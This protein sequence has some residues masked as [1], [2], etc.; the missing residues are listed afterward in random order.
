MAVNNQKKTKKKA[1]VSEGGI[2]ALYCRLSRDDGSEGESNSIANQKKLLAR[3]AKDHGLGNTK[4]YV[5]DGYTGTN[6]NRPGFQ[7]MLE[8]MDMG[9][10]STVIVKDS[11]RFGRNYLE[12]GKYTDYYFPEHNIRFIAVND[13]EDRLCENGEDELGAFRNVMNEMYAKDISRK[14]RSSQRLRGMAGEPLSPPP[15]GYV[16]SP[17]NKKKWVIDPEAA[18]IVRKIFRL[19]LEGKGNEVIARQLQDE[20]VLVPQAY[21]QSKGLGRGGKKTQPNPYRWCKTT[22]GKILTQQ[23]YCGDVINFKTYSKSFRNKTRVENPQENWAVFRDVHEP[24]IDRETFEEVQKIVNKVRQRRLKDPEEEKSLFTNLLYCA[25]CGSRLWYH[26]ST[27]QTPVRHFFCSNYKGIR[28]TCED[29]HYIRED[30]L[31]E[32]VLSELR[33]L[34]AYLESDEDAFAELLERKSNADMIAEQKA[35]EAALATA[36]ARNAEVL[37]M[38]EK[39]YE[40]NVNGKVTDEWFMQLSHRY[41]DEKAALKKQIFE[42]NEKLN[43][44]AEANNSKESFIR[45]IRSFLKVQRLTPTLLRELIDRIDAH[46]VKGKG[47]SRTQEIVI[48]YRFIGVIDV[49]YVQHRRVVFETRQGVA[50][51]YVPKGTSTTA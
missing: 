47:K 17:E 12:V 21:W 9:Y 37:R 15:Y 32:I 24:I 28:G 3:Y 45:A 43:R 49:P 48:H 36:N 39:V 26:K 27:N 5:D 33:R 51:E 16:K 46:A 22:I 35:V 23:E 7:Q 44:L 50:I 30:A 20:K 4:F 8:D 14:V 31:T 40:D 2:T 18:E 11:S 6:F 38:Y 29:H 19:C 13:C 25:D 41:E 42:L 10:I 1:P 34:A